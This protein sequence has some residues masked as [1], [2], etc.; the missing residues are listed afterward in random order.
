MTQAP[1]NS[2]RPAVAAAGLKIIFHDSYVT[3]SVDE[4]MRLVR[5]VRSATPFPDL[6]ALRRTY[7]TIIALLNKMERSHYSLLTDI[8]S[9]PGRNDPAFELLMRD[10]R[11]RAQRGFARRGTLV[12]TAVGAMQARRLTKEEGLERMISSDETELLRYLALE[13]E[14]G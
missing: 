6:D 8:R 9:A 11:P 13:S 14:P 7:E 2:E 3:V 1:K 10:L 5:S 12:A 4:S